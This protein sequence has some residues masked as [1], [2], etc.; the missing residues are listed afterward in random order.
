MSSP[1]YMT[2]QQDKPQALKDRMMRSLHQQAQLQVVNYD[3][4]DVKMNHEKLADKVTRL[5]DSMNAKAPID[6][7]IELK[8]GMS[9]LNERIIF[10]ENSLSAF[11]TK[12]AMEKEL[13][14][15]G[16]CLE[17]IC[18]TGHTPRQTVDDYS[19]KIQDLEARVS[20]LSSLGDVVNE[21]RQKID[22]MPK[23]NIK[24]DGADGPLFKRPDKFIRK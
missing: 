19:R 11:V 24:T 16:E 2:E 18:G 14:D 12:S 1:I 4:S 23:V 8:C 3:L 17:M 20:E 15:I 10:L 21:L 5:Q 13:A 9:N 7:I 22:E 6:S